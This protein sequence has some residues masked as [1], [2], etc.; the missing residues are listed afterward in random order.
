MKEYKAVFEAYQEEG[1]QVLAISEDNSKTQSKVKPFISSNDY[2]Y[3]VLLDPTAEVLKS[4]G[5]MS[6]PYTIVL[7]TEGKVQKIYR[8][9]IG[10]IDELTTL[11]EGLLEKP[12]SE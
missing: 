1:I 7:D 11:L 8:G 3:T 2:S 4:Y 12:S 6:I 9:K 10:K 5:G